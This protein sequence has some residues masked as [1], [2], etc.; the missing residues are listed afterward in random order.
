MEACGLRGEGGCR[1]NLVGV[2]FEFFS[3]K[4]MA[5]VCRLPSHDFDPEGNDLS[6]LYD[7][8]TTNLPHPAMA[9]SHF[10]FPPST[11]LYPRAHV[12]QTYLEAYAA[13]FHLYALIRLNTMV[14]HA[15][16]NSTKW[17]VR[18]SNGEEHEFDFLVVASGHF[19]VPRYPD[20]PGLSEWLASEKASHS[21]YYRR[22]GNFGATVLVVGDGSSGRDISAEMRGSSKT[23]IR[24]VPGAVSLDSGNLKIRGRVKEFR[25]AGEVVFEDGTSEFDVDHCI[26]ATGYEMSFPFFPQDVLPS[27]PATVSPLPTVVYNSGWHIFPLAQHL[28]PLG[29][30][31]P[32]TSLAFV[33]L[34]RLT[35]PLPLA[36][37]QAHAIV[38]VLAHPES[39]DITRE[40]AEVIAR[41]KKLR[42]QFGNDTLTIAKRWHVFEGDEFFESLDWLR[43]FSGAGRRTPDWFRA[44]WACHE[45][46][47]ALWRALEESGE[48]A[49]LVKGVGEGGEHEWVDLMWKLLERAGNDE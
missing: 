37:A 4:S 42:A 47:P 2:H 16:W 23:L 10:P 21:A 33:A 43:E 3:P 5:A 38:R 19:S 11:P 15:H 27:L 49:E 36:E 20:T 24:S 18:V 8:L 28:F 9:Y 40:R 12:V 22:P 34:P 25:R 39:L 46:L 26:L 29:D 32:S 31:F 1:W 7:S 13:E 41:Y 30:K 48:A 17:L 45:T 35:S 14:K 44:F 6:R